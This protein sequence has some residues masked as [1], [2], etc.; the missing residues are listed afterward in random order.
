MPRRATLTAAILLT[1][2]ATQPAIGDQMTEDQAAVLAVVQGMTANLEQGNVDAIMSA[3]EDGA[4]IL[5][6]PGTPV[7]DA[8]AV[9][10]AFA[11]LASINPNFTYAG[12]EVIVTGDI[13]V[14]LAPWSMTATAPDGADIAQS[15]LSVAIF[16]RQPD[17]TWRMVIDNPHGDHLMPR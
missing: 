8:A 3:Y 12:H 13:A 16:R 10:Q 6:E 14:H 11:Q 9:R 17:D 1:L 15:G 2:A 4:S 7:S 5:F